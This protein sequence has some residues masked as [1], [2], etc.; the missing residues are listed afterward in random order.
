MRYMASLF[1]A[2]NEE[3][4]R[5]VYRKLFAVRVLMRSKTVGNVP[6]AE[7]DAAL[8][9]GRTTAE[10]AEAIFQLT[11]K[12]TFKERFV[13]PPLAREQALEAAGDPFDRKREGGFGFRRPG[14][15]RF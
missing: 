11:S 15:R 7:V 8:E 12:P 2:G 3:V 14:E 6:E 9:S 1:S 10:E 5:D 4:V 13:L